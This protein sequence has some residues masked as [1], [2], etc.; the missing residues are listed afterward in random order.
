M[1]SASRLRDSVVPSIADRITSVDDARYYAERRVPRFLREFIRNGSGERTTLAANTRAF[2]DVT[3]RP[4]AAVR[5]TEPEL[6]MTVLG[7]RISLPVM[8]AP[9]GGARMVHPDGERAGVRAAGAAGT[10]Q[11]V[12]SFTAVPIEE[13]TAAA[14]GPVCFQLYYPGSL[15]D[16][17]AMIQRVQRAGCAGL[18]LT[19]DSAVGPR[20]EVPARRRV[21]LY[22]AGSMTPRPAI[23]YV[24]IVGQCARRPRWAAAFARDRARGFNAAMVTE[25]GK[26]VM[27][28]RASEILT[29]RTPIWEDIPWIRKRWNGPLVI[30]GILT[31][32]DARRAVD[33]GADAI[34]VSNHGGNVLDGNPATL[35]V[36]GEIVQEVGDRT[37]VL[38]DGGI[39]RGS[40]VVKAMAIGARAVLV[41]RSWLW[42]LAAAGEDGVRAVLD[43][44]R[45]QIGDTLS[46]LGCDSVSDLDRSYVRCPEIWGQAAAPLSPKPPS[47]GEPQEPT[48]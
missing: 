2:A 38:F 31:P 40:D 25:N 6:T 12:T 24:R 15:E 23:E 7:H 28:F 34:V 18:M 26:P 5:V 45:R 17:G 13:I 1:T 46:S 39:R 44:Y 9:T 27:V 35:S 33:Y 19:V 21:T 16:A 14:S 30:K 36:L 29:R 8:I 11:W 4:R 10:I 22:R 48:L 3:F 32:E 43:V 42:G 47:V 37:E 20:P 41:G